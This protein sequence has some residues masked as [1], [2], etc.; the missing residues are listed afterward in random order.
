MFVRPSGRS[1]EGT[2]VPAPVD[3]AEAL[4]EAPPVQRAPEDGLL[5]VLE[6]ADPQ[7][8][9]PEGPGALD[10]VGPGDGDDLELDPPVV[11]PAGERVRVG[12]PNPRHENFVVVVRGGEGADPQDERHRSSPRRHAL[13]AAPGEDEGP[14]ARARGQR[15][16]ERGGRGGT[17]AERKGRRANDAAMGMSSSPRRRK[18]S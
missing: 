16:R 1:L 9:L 15:G 14:G 7:E 4:E 6:V 11:K 8:E 13:G 5:V 17:S 3:V 10:I 12:P 18:D 2:G